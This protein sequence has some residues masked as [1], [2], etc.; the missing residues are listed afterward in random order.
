MIDHKEAVRAFIE[1]PSAIKSDGAMRL[2]E[3]SPCLSSPDNISS[4]W[5]AIGAVKQTL[6]N[7][8]LGISIRPYFWPEWDS[9]MPFSLVSM[10]CVG[11]EK[12]Q[13]GRL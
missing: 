4:K 1:N 3:A 11:L 13:I 12:R 8:R 10:E 5:E 2:G 7:L 9:R 6:V